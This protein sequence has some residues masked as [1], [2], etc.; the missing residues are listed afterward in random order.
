MLLSPA[1]AMYARLDKDKWVRPLKG[2]LFTP[3]DGEGADLL[4]NY[5]N[6]LLQY[7]GKEG[8]PAEKLENQKILEVLEQVCKEWGKVDGKGSLLRRKLAEG[9]DALPSKTFDDCA[10]ECDKEGLRKFLGFI[11]EQNEKNPFNSSPK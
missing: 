9:K 8:V 4:R 1:T 7:L 3:A 11:V 10:E 5:L 6:S 2:P